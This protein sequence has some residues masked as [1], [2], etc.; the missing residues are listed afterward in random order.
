MQ[1]T[2]KNELCKRN[3]DRNSQFDFC[4][5]CTHMLKLGES[6]SQRRSTN[7]SRQN[8][9]RTEVFDN[10]REISGFDFSSPNNERVSRPVPAPVSVASMM[11]SVT[12]A[13]STL[14]SVKSTIGSTTMVS[15]TV[16][17][18]APVIDIN[19]LYSNL[20]TMSATTTP[21]ESSNAIKDMYGML[22][23]LVKKS[24]EADHMKKDITLNT[25]RI[26]RL[27]AKIGKPDEI[28][29]TLSL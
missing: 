11:T 10:N 24:D 2:C 29:T 22:V 21:T 6:Q 17:V 16:P 13:N 25:Q 9:A 27:E 23:H 26:D 28:A 15:T 5:Q 1:K 14:P 8:K 7:Q 4:P 12:T 19:R 18:P 20:Q 3:V